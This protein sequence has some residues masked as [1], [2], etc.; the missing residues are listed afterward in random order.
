MIRPIDMSPFEF[1]RV[2]SLRVAQ[3]VQGCK[4]RVAP[5]LR[6]TTTA[7]LEVASRMVE[8]VPPIALPTPTDD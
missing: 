3:L 6:H 4:P 1:V 7:Q 5:G 8:R 2:S